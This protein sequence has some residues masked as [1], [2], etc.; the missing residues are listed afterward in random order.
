MYA[1]HPHGALKPVTVAFPGFCGTNMNRKKSTE[2]MAKGIK[3]S[4]VAKPLH[5]K[6]DLS[7]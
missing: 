1:L 2:K 5:E 7:Q 4:P 6:G 3:W